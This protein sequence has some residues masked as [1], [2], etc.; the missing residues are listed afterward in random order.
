M[1][2]QISTQRRLVLALVVAVLAAAHVLWFDYASNQLGPGGSDFDQLWFAARAVLRRDDP[3]PLIGPGRAFV[4][5]WP[6]LYPLPT[7]IA[8]LP[9]AALSLLPARVLFA[10]VSAAVLAFALTRRGWGLLPMLASAAVLDAVRG[11]QLSP[12]LTAGL[13]SSWASFA[14]ILKPH[15]G[16]TLLAASPRRRAVLITIVTAIILT[17][18]AFAVQP[19]WVA[20]WRKGLGTA[21]HM[22]APVLALGG[23]LLLLA[24]LRWRRFDARVLLTCACVPHTPMI[25][26]VVPLALVARNFRESLAYA[27]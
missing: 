3:Y 5:S 6:L 14:F 8:I 17:A 23:P 7:I 22:R 4:W 2:T 21:S 20:G 27:L 24:L 25:Y 1:S 9:F 15:T 10:S 26:D 19:G 12:L 18:V 13:L 16:L 11:A